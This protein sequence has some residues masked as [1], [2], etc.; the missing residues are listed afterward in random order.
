MLTC[1]VADEDESWFGGERSGARAVD[2]EASSV[3]EFG[4]RGSSTRHCTE[5]EGGGADERGPWGSGTDVWVWEWTTALMGW[6]TA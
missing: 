4:A 2:D 6:A 1:G 3:A 5:E